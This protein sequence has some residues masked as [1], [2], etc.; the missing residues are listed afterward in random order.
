MP[1]A[2][3]RAADR[4]F[5][6][7]IDPLLAARSIAPGIYTLKGYVDDILAQTSLQG[8]LWFQRR[9]QTL[10]TICPLQV[11]HHQCI[12]TNSNTDNPLSTTQASNYHQHAG[13]H[14]YQND[15]RSPKNR[16]SPNHRTT[17]VKPPCNNIILITCTSRN[18]HKGQPSH[19]PQS[20]TNIPTEN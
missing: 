10:T 17:L 20:P 19:T 1:G 18:S 13:T 12:E 5:Q 8:A 2:I 14:N 15:P 6:G 11:K 16:I 3:D 9:I 4:I 7:N